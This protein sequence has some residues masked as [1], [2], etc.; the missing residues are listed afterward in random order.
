ML[1]EAD[2]LGGRGGLKVPSSTNVGKLLVTLFFKDDDFQK[3]MARAG[4][5]MKIS[6]DGM[7]NVASRVQSGVSTAF[8]VAGAAMTAFGVASIAVGS[9]FEHQMAVVS[10][11]TNKTGEDLQPLID[12]A[13]ELGASTEFTA[14]QAGEGL[15]ALARAGLSAEQSMTAAGDALR[16][17]GVNGAQL[18]DSANLVAATM[19]Q[20]GLDATQSTRIVDVFS[21]SMRSSLLDFESIREAMKFAG[22]AGASFGMSIE[23]TTA[24]VAAFR[25]LGLEGSLAGTNFRMS[26][27]QAAKGT[28]QQAAAL[29]KYG[30]QL[31]DINPETN[32]FNEI[33]GKMAD[34]GLTASDAITIFGARSGANIAKLTGAIRTGQI[35]L[36]GFTESMKDSAGTTEDMWNTTGET[37][38]FQAKVM[39]SALQ[40]LLIE[41][42][43]TFKGPLREMIAA[44]PLVL[45]E[46]SAALKSESGAISKV[47]KDTLGDITTFLLN[48]STE[49][50]N[51]FVTMVK[52]TVDFTAAMSPLIKAF[53][54]LSGHVEKVL[55]AMGVLFVTTGAIAMSGA[56]TSLGA[57]FGVAGTAVTAF[58]VTLTVST[59]GL[60]AIAAAIAAV[61]AAIA[62]Y[63]GKVKA[64]RDETELLRAAQERL[65]AEAEQ[66]AQAEEKRLAPALEKQQAAARK[67]LET[68]ESL[69]D[70]QRRRLEAVLAL[71]VETARLQ[72]N[73]GKLI[74]SGGELLTVEDLIRKGGKDGITVIRAQADAL[75]ENVKILDKQIA[76]AQ[77]VAT[78]MEDKNQHTQ[79]TIA[80]QVI[81]NKL[82]RDDIQNMQDAQAAID[83]LTAKR[84]E[85]SRRAVALRNEISSASQRLLQEN[86]QVQL[87]A[88]QAENRS[89]EDVAKTA[90]EA[91]QKAAEATQALMQSLRDDALKI[92]DDEIELALRAREKKIEEVNKAFDEEVRLA[93]ELGEETQKIEENRREALQQVNANFIAEAEKEEEEHQAELRQIRIDAEKEAGDILADLRAQEVSVVEALEIDKFNTLAELTEASAETRAAIEAEFDKQ[94][95]QHKRQTLIA[96]FGDIGMA[97]VNAFGMASGAAVGLV[98]SLTGMDISL[99]GILATTKEITAALIESGQVG[100][101]V[102]ET[103]NTNAMVDQM[104]DAAIAFVEQVAESAPIIIERLGERIPDLIASIAASLPALVE[105]LVAELPRVLKAILDAIPGLVTALLGSIVTI[106]D[107]IPLLVRQLLKALPSIITAILEGIPQIIRAI[108]RAIPQILDALIDSLPAIIHA[109]IAG[110]PG[111]VMALVRAVPQIVVSVIEAIPQLIAAILGEIPFLITTIIG[112]IPNIIIALA[113]ALPELL[114][115]IVMLIP[116]VV[117][118]IVKALPEIVFALVEGIVVELIGKMPRI[119]FALVEGILESVLQIGKEIG[120]AIVAIIPGIGGKDKKNKKGGKGFDSDDSGFIKDIG[121]AIGSLFKKGSSSGIQ[122][123]P[124]TMRT[125]LHP[126]EAVLNADENRARMAGGRAGP[127]QAGAALGAGAAAAGGGSGQRIEVMVVAEGRLLDAVQVESMQRGRATGVKRIIR[128]AS[129]A[130][131]GFTR[132]RFNA[133]TP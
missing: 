8:K 68:D 71:S 73:Q 28:D 75:N 54:F 9:G 29:K 107:V 1:T 65:T 113:N 100:R 103:G 62:I 23:E 63:I 120:K 48:N 24:A 4:R 123:V 52:L 2:T 10:A 117:V 96:A 111:I 108:V 14:T 99:R 109:V 69:T 106:I 84:T 15:E 91:R 26:M 79:D 16:F 37:V 56:V 78:A 124:A 129:G 39:I 121:E 44:I 86:K 112:M 51:S 60:F 42:F 25:D 80:R 72:I 126:G 49:I 94:I 114:P 83:Q 58:G 11:I 6:G 18:G 102:G 36:V 93:T 53:I 82:G 90:I 31:K 57:A 30:L 97:A 115:A 13:R 132:G 131:V 95:A 21:K 59:G 89:I 119:V 41:T 32:S 17:A 5:T 74:E 127:A 70:A 101:G 76:A 87:E 128:R 64:A 34:V 45:N 92:A 85:E 33:M 116:E 43:D 38:Q 66:L 12:K 67:A 27:I 105:G 22:T 88:H 7:I 130:K 81:A 122:Y 104:V 110:I 98:S 47:V 118:E 50:A 40:D 20:F 55:L 46:T 61:V 35:D 77:E 133:W 19:K 125:V 3:G